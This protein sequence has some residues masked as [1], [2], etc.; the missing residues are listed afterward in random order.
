MPDQAFDADAVLKLLKKAKASG[1]E[2]PFAFGLAGKPED[3]GL[4]I[5][6]RKPGKVLRG[7]MK[8][9]PG[10]KKS[11]FGTLRVEENEVLLQPEKPLKGIVKQLKKKFMKEGM[12]KFK[13]VLV[14]PD[15]SI[16]DEDSLPDDDDTAGTS[17]ETRPAEDSTPDAGAAAALKSRIAAA[18]EAVKA[19]GKP[20]LAGKLAPE[21]KASVKLLGQGDHDACAARLD[22]LEAALAKLGGQPKPAPADPAQSEQAAKLGKLLTAQAAKLKSLPPEQAAPL[23]EQARAIAANL[24]SGALPA[25]ADGLKALIKALDTPAGDTAPQADVMEIWQAAKE[26]VDR[27][28]SSLQDAL[29]S[30]NHPV[31]AQ[32]ADAGLAGVTD[33]NQTALMKALFEMKSA[34]GDARKKAAQ[35]LLAQIAAYLKFLKDDPVIG[36]VEDNPF[37]VKAPVKTPLTNALRQMAEIAK[38]A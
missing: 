4:M 8:K 23:A 19:L 7:D 22:R 38:A 26:D 32:I 11:C 1:K 37:G 29:K 35:A 16:I 2:L 33:G 15:G 21:I 14:G 30:H 24:K 5:D 36:M 20:D 3:C 27:G 18:A 6:L 13:P 31:L 34:A 17:P 28:V 10:I 9:A 25:A 12:V